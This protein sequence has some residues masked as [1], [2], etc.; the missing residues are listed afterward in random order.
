MDLEGRINGMASENA[1]LN[2]LNKDLMTK[3]NELMHEL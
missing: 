3:L 1:R 2:D